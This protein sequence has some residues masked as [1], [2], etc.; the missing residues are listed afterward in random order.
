[1]SG[2]STSFQLPIKTMIPA[3]T[4][5]GI[6]S[7]QMMVNRMRHSLHPSMRAASRRSVGSVRKLCRRMST[8]VAFIMNG[9]ISP[10]SESVQPNLTTSV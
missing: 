9:T 2:H 10:T 1:M 6:E 4:R 3:V 5:A 7:G 8:A